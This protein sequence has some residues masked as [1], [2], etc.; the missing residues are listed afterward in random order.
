MAKKISIKF[1]PTSQQQN[2]S[3]LSPPGTPT[4]LS[5][6]G[7]PFDD[8][9]ITSEDDLGSVQ[10]FSITD[11]ESEDNSES[12]GDPD[13]QRQSQ[14][15]HQQQNRQPPKVEDEIDMIDAKIRQEKKKGSGNK[16]DKFM[17]H[18]QEALTPSSS[19][20][21]LNQDSSK[22]P[23]KHDIESETTT[24][25]SSLL[26]SSTT[27]N[28][29]STSWLNDIKFT[30]LVNLNKLRNEKQQ[31]TKIMQSESMDNFFDN[32]QQQ[33]QSQPTTTGSTSRKMSMAIGV[34]NYNH[35]ISTSS[36]SSLSTTAT[37]TTMTTTAATTTTM[38]ADAPTTIMMMT[39]T[40][41][42]IV[43]ANGQIM[44]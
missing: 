16:M 4:E 6:M 20:S 18:L 43:D 14:Q 37:T 15:L 41:S 33:Q 13:C 38:V 24:S 30:N 25:S 44:V 19:S 36:S 23:I 11:E 31:Q 3:S 12:I 40:F 22:N 1:T 17:K 9:A 39:N 8:F 26:S 7:S 32:Q 28:Q 35:P 21:L 29:N 42:S 10:L 34:K 2:R 5:L 27:N